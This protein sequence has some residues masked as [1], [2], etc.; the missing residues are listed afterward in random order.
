MG[1]VGPVIPDSMKDMRLDDEAKIDLRKALDDGVAAFK[2]ST[3]MLEDFG[4][5]IPD[6]IHAAME[7]LKTID[8][9][10]LTYGKMDDLQKHMRDLI[11]NLQNKMEKY[12]SRLPTVSKDVKDSL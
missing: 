11:K 1:E 3:E 5:S 7:V 6:S 2:K 12:M 10:E 4:I 8:I 9:D